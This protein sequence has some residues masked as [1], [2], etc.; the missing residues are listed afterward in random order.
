VIVNNKF[1]YF[2]KPVKCRY[3]SV[4]A[5]PITAAFLEN[6]YDSSLFPP[7]WKCLTRYTKIKYVCEQRNKNIRTTTATII[8]I[9]III[10]LIYLCAHNSH[11]SQLE[12]ST[13]QQYKKYIMKY[14]GYKDKRQIKKKQTKRNIQHETHII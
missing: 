7:G 13:K 14:K 8:I 4:V 2:R 5:D 12:T 9:I 6:R 1:K 3:R 10:Q 11:K